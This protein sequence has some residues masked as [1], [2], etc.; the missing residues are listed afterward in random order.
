MA[1]HPDGP[2][3]RAQQRHDW[4][5]ILDT[6]DTFQQQ[7]AISPSQRMIARALSM[8]APSVVHHA[9][10]GLH[11]QGLL[12]ITPTQPG[13]PA[14]LE[15]TPAGRA[16]LAAWRAG[17][18]TAM[19]EVQH[20]SPCAHPGPATRR[21]PLGAAVCRISTHTTERHPVPPRS[22]SWFQLPTPTLRAGGYVPC[23]HSA[24]AC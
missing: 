16:R 18:A 21:S 4:L 20:D 3:R 6:I 13:W 22:P 14:N 24:R 8:P 10:H 23:P 15:I 5:A 7:Q 11:R 19:T 17:R 12:T 2:S 1:S 9:L